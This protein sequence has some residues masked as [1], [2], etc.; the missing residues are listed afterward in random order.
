MVVPF[1]FFLLTVVCIAGLSGKVSAKRNDLHVSKTLMQFGCIPGSKV[2]PAQMYCLVDINYPYYGTCACAGIH[3]KELA[4]PKDKGNELTMSKSVNDCKPMAF[5]LWSSV[6][7]WFCLG[8]LYSRL[9][10]GSGMMVYR[11]Y[12]KGGAKIN[13]SFLALFGCIGENFGQFLRCVLYVIVRANWDK[14]WTII[15]AFWG[16]PEP[17]TIV[18]GC[19][20]RLFIIITWFD[21]FQK[22][23]KLSKRSSETVNILR[24]ASQLLALVY[25][26]LGVWLGMRDKYYEDV[27]ELFN[28]F[29]PIFLT[30][31]CAGVAPLIIRALCKDMRNVTHPNWKAA[32]AIRRCAFNE[33][34][35]QAALF[36]GVRAYSRT[37]F[38]AYQAGVVGNAVLPVIWFYNVN[39]CG[40]WFSY[41]IFAHRRNLENTET[42]RIRHLFGFNLPWR[43][44]FAGGR[45]VE[46]K[47]SSISEVE[48]SGSDLKT[49]TV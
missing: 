7:I 4:P 5:P 37:S 23:V 34:F 39:A 42:E 2:C 29:Q 24:Y 10:I 3:G 35:S 14:K 22:S 12:K 26:V 15:D 36:L 31:V 40:E 27:V 16:F 21:L 28:S 18:F 8:V 6:M 1:R 32:S 9:V 45:F 11:I 17:V 33:P 44:L 38:W 49:V 48:P 19:T 13:S 43:R 20:Y 25:L 41:L 46:E 30:A 47:P